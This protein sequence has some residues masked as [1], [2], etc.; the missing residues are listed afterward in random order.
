[1]VV[2]PR[3]RTASTA[4]PTGQGSYPRRTVV[5]LTVPR[6]DYGPSIVAA[7][8]GPWLRRC[9]M[10]NSTT[11][12]PGEPRGYSRG[13]RENHGQTRCACGLGQPNVVGDERRNALPDATSWSARRQIDGVQRAQMWIDVGRP[14]SPARPRRC[15]RGQSWPV[16]RPPRRA[17]SAD[18]AAVPAAPRPRPARTRHPPLFEL[19]VQPRDERRRLLFHPA[20]RR[21][22][23]HAAALPNG[24]W[25]GGHTQPLGAD[26]RRALPA[27][28]TCSR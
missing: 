2:M 12:L 14:P 1:M 23:C 7:L 19:P 16:W 6:Y 20:R 28:V 26:R 13:A 21:L 8:L 22:I 4:S 27:F 5:S 11:C 10:P 25:T 18:C 17:H 15:R 24:H 9:S 3:S